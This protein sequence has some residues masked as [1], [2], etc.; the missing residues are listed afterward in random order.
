MTTT[1]KEKGNK[2][3]STRRAEAV[4]D[5]LKAIWNIA[6]ERMTIEVR[7]LPA[8]PSSIRLKEGQAENRRVE[9]YSMDPAILAPIRSTYLTTRI[10]A[11]TLTLRSDVVAP[12]GIAQLEDNRRQCL[13]NPGRSGRKGGS[14]QGDHV[15]RWLPEISRPW[16]PAAISW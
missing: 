9:I 5:Y 12:Y 1:G 13:G 16:P 4:R 2:K 14:R 10:D 3:L 8:K 15:S 6:P 7:N 11:S